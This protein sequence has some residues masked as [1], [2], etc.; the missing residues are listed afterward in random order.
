MKESNYIFKENSLNS[1][2]IDIFNPYPYQISIKH[3]EFPIVFYINFFNEGIR[4]QR[5]NL[6]LPDSISAINPGDTLSVNCSFNLGGLTDSTY[7]IV[8]SSEAGPLYDPFNSKF[9]TASIIR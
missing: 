9:S 1:F 3:K 4:E 8:I 6:Q 5:L 2:E 7:L